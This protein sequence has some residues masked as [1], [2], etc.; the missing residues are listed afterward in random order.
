MLIHSSGVVPSG[1]QPNCHGG[2]DSGLAVEHARE[3]HA[4]N[5]QMGHGFGYGK[6]S[7]IFAE[8]QAGMWR[9]THAF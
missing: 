1:R 2:R 4:C 9:I 5:S 7:E 6:V 3:R 8:N